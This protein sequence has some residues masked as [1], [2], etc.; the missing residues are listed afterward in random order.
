MLPSAAACCS[1]WCSV[2]LVLLQDNRVRILDVDKFKASQAL[3]VN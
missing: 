3:Q 1:G 2:V